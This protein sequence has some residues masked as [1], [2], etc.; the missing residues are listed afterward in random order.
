MSRPGGAWAMITASVALVA[1]ASAAPDPPSPSIEGA[2][3]FWERVNRAPPTRSAHAITYD[4]IRHTTLL[5]GG[6]TAP[7]GERLA[8][9]WEWNGTSWLPRAERGPSARSRHALVFDTAHDVAL[10][11]GGEDAA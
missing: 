11:F 6:E 10:L 4:S 2:P 8:D 9:T 7:G 5:F 3:V 1:V